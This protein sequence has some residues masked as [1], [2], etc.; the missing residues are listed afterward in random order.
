[1]SWTVPTLHVSV[2]TAPRGVPWQA[3]P[4]VASGRMSISH[5]GMVL[6]AK[7]LA[8]TRV[9]LLDDP[10]A[11]AAVRAEL[12]RRTQGFVHKAYVPDGPPPLPVTP[13]ER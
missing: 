4:V 10:A 5:K 7:T 2:T 12:G 9:E 11:R 8:A 1:V 6:G 3:W 13:T